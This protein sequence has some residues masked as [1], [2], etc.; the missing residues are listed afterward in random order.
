MITSMSILWR[1]QISIS[2]GALW[3]GA[4]WGGAVS[5]SKSIIFDEWK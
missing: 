5:Q 3:G 4:L 2:G 1:F